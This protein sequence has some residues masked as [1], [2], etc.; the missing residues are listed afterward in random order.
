MQ[1]G[2]AGHIRVVAD[3]QL[4]GGEDGDEAAL[5]VRLAA[6]QL[7]DPVERRVGVAAGGVEDAVSVRG[8]AEVAAVA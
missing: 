6:Q 2:Q 4:V 8:P 3:G 5:A 7:Q 1:R